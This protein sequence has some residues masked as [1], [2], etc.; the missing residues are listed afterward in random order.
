MAIVQLPSPALFAAGIE[1]RWDEVDP[2]TQAFV[3]PNAFVSGVPWRYQLDDTVQI[4]VNET[5]PRVRR[6]DCSDTDF[7]C[8]FWQ[9]D[10]ILVAAD[11][12]PDSD[13]LQ[14]PIRLKF[15][16]GVRAVGAWVGVCPRDPFDAPFFDQPLFAAMWV[17]L[18]SDPQDWQMVVNADGR[19]GHV[20]ACATPLSAP[21]V[22]AR[23]TGGDRIVEVRFDASLLGNRRYDK[24]ALSE[25]T[26]ER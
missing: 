23:A 16:A 11:P 1:K 6:R 25:L 2:F 17:A 13:V 22:G 3:A 19:T 4:T 26:V 15:S 20:C 12:S 14:A 10:A 18:A 9:G 8:N 5:G 7:D 21:F 24:L